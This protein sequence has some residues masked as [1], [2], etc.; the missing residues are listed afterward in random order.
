MAQSF[1]L[2]DLLGQIPIGDIAADFGVDESTASAAVKQALPGLLG[3]LAVNAGDEEGANKLEQ[4]LEKHRGSEA[5]GRLSAIDT[6]DGEKIVGHVLGAKQEEVVQ[7]LGA[8]SGDS[9]IAALI[10]KLLPILAPI[11]MQFLA[12]GLGTQKSE[13]AAD[14]EPAGGGL[15]DLLGGLLGGGSQSGSGGGLGDLL[16]GL[17]GGGGSGSSGGGLGDLLGGILGGR[18]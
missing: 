5:K 3:G 17:L 15:G 14:S 7:A 4:A 16:G 11:I 9:G 1:N 2:D 13:S 12:N 18:K 10:P 8:Q 6:A